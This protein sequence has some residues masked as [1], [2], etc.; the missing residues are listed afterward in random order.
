VSAAPAKEPVIPRFSK[1]A[2]NN[3][4]KSSKLK[5]CLVDKCREREVSCIIKNRGYLE[6]WV[7]NC[8]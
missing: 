6:D 3:F 2:E 4:L 8:N 1:P 5:A 7:V